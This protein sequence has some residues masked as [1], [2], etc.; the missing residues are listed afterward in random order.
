MKATSTSLNIYSLCITRLYWFNDYGAMLFIPTLSMQCLRMLL[1]SLLDGSR[2][3]KDSIRP[4]YK[5]T[6]Y[7]GI[8]VVFRVSS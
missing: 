5:R 6:K 2:Q 8:R 3:N 4:L 1:I 7:N